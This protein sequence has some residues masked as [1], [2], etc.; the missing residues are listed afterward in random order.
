MPLYAAVAASL[1]LWLALIGCVLFDA[2]L[3]GAGVCI[4]LLASVEMA[5]RVIEG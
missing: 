5:E 1:G 3:I 4:F 2:Q